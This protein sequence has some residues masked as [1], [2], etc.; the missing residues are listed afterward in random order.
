M[1]DSVLKH[2]KETL[3]KNNFEPVKKLG[4]GGFGVVFL[5]EK[6][7]STSEL[8]SVKCT[9]KKQFSKKPA[10]RR[11]LKQEISL[12]ETLHSPNIVRLYRTIEGNL[13][14]T[15]MIIGSSW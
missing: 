4:M 1:D 8:F 14:L 3:K 5:V 10:M 6:V 11:Y 15:Q 13:L 7:G 2:C 9:F 12:M